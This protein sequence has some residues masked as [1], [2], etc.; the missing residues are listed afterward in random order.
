MAEWL[1]RLSVLLSFVAVVAVA[2]PA[3][4]QDDAADDD[5]EDS[6]E[7]TLV[8]ERDAT[9]EFTVDEGTWMSLDVSPDGSTIVFDLLGDIYTLPVAGGEAM[10][11]IAG[12]SF[13]SQ[14]RFSPDGRTIAFLSDRSGV[15]NLW[16]AD[17]DGANPRAVTKDGITKARPQAMSS[18]VWT[19]DGEYIVVSKVR[20]PERTHALFMFH[21]DG[22]SGVRI[23]SEPPPPSSGGNGPRPRPPNR[24]GAVA[25][26][27]GRFI[28]YTER[29]GSFSYNA[30]FPIWQVIRFDRDTGETAT[31]TNAQGSAMRPVLSPDGTQLVY[32]TRFETQAGLR[33]RDLE[34]GDERW[35]IYPVTRDDQESRASRDT[36]PGYAFLPDG[37]ALVV[38]IDGKIAKVDFE[39]GHTEPIPFTAHVAAEVGPRVYFEN[40]IDDSPMVRARL[41]RWPAVSP[42][43]AQ[44][45]FSAL[46]KLWV[47]DLPD[48]AATRLT[49]LETNEFMPSWSPDG[50]HVTF[51]TW[52][53]DGG[54]VYRATPEGGATPERLTARAGYYSEPVYT[55]DGSRVVFLAGSA[56]DQLYADFRD[57]EASVYREIDPSAPAE[58]SGVRSSADLDLRWIPAEGGEWTHIGSTQGGSAPHFAAETDPERVYLT[59]SGELTS[60]RL[61]GFDRRTH[62]K[63]TGV[64]AGENP[65]SASEIKLSPDGTR[66]FISLQNKHYLARLPKAGG[67]TL[68]L[69]ITGDDAAVPVTD[70]SAE[71]G[72][73]LSWSADGTAVYWALGARIYRQAIEAIETIDAI[74]AEVPEVFEAVVE[75][76]RYAPQGDVILSGARIV[77]M[78]A[79]EVIER[80]D[81]LVSGNRIAAVGP[82]GTLSVPD[83]A[84]VIDVAGKT[85]MPGFVDVHAH[86]WAPWGVH[87]SQVWQYLANLAYGV[88]TTRD[89]QTSR[90]DVFAYADL[91][92]TGEILG[93]R[94][95]ATG[96][97]VFSRSGVT[98]QEAA[99]N[100]IKRYRE[101]Y[102]TDTIKAYVSGD[103]LVRQWVIKAARE[104]GIMPTTEGALDMKLDLSQMID[105]FTG[106]EHSLP[107][108]PIYDDV[109]QFVA[110]TRTYYTPTILV[111]YGAPWSENY[112]FEHEDPHSNK[113]MRRF[114]PHALFDTM[115]RRRGQWFMDEEY[116]HTGIA[117]GVRKV[118]EAGG[119]VGLGSHGQFQGLGAHWEIWNLQSGGLSPHDT[120]RVV[121]IF[122]AEAL[123]LQRDLG[124]VSA[125]K[126]ADLVVLD[127]NPLE[128]IRHT[129]TLRYVMKN[130]E[131][132][133]ADTLDRIWPTRRPLPR[134]YWWD[135]DPE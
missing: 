50:Q 52:S 48:G 2:L 111:A 24:L 117:D 78:N 89:P 46:H 43:G 109:A 103:R 85:I 127:E 6:K 18:P 8:L 57:W 97:G 104:F 54:H 95:L 49:N 80:G 131:L 35:L 42:D 10:Q 112:Y 128:D 84:R 129:D 34:T 123:G 125:G 72:D 67:E 86:M 71:G 66:V 7:Q 90:P 93:P 60:I 16:L 130:G 17:T 20:A 53:G 15:E 38:P 91:V 26:P 31:I 114:I 56:N 74:D 44:V 118:V 9:L 100:F 14:P 23:G 79:Y 32:A 135:E 13:E 47:M 88:T 124:S 61:D 28:Y 77:T 134:Q 121:T 12:M 98:D 116:G 68:T 70:L 30:Q 76:P 25:S 126:L 39:T 65:P 45:A 81:L 27:D 108:H 99:T 101:A 69:R 5:G 94:I 3:L 40:E 1:R 59:D 92:E 73:F 21:K 36:M 19:P 37:S 87:Q 29:D 102:R 120:L 55:P 75:A 4:A 22:G 51:V 107:I 122:G 113:K 115:V 64:G 105:G 41:V 11:I 62:L 33:V 106:L 132:F 119:R 82:S 83:G 58:I 96:P 133:E 110:R 63:V